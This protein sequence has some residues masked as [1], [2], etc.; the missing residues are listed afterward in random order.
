MH[1]P[2]LRRRSNEHG[3]RSRPRLPKRHPKSSDRGRPA[4]HLGLEEWLRVKRSIRRSG[5][6]NDLI[7]THK[8][9]L[10]QEIQD[11]DSK[12]ANLG[13]MM[14][15]EQGG[16][17]DNL[18]KQIELARME[19]DIQKAEAF[20]QTIVD[21]LTKLTKG[22]AFYTSSGELANCIMESYLSGRKKKAHIA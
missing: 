11:I 16:V 14:E 12:I 19:S 18:S 9:T 17:R 22:V 4:R 10:L 5:D 15:K 21:Q 1:S 2:S 8:E 7:E 13:K 20:R 3:A 6:C